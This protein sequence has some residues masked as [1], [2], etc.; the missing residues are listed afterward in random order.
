MLMTG[1]PYF[2]I[3]ENTYALWEYP[4]IERGNSPLL[5]FPEY[6]KSQG[7]YTFSSGKHHN[8]KYWIERGFDEIKA[9]FLGGMS[10]HYGLPVKDYDKEN[11]WSKVY[12]ENKLFSSELFANA[13]IDFLTEYQNDKPF[14]MYLSFTAP[15]DPRTSP[16]DFSDLYADNDISLP[17]NFMAKHPFPIADMRSRDELLAKFPR[18]KVD[19]K[20]QIRDY[21]AM[22]SATDHHIGRVLKQLKTSGFDENTVVI[23]AGDNGLALGQ[24]G[25]L[26]K[27]SVY[28]HS[29]KIPL[30]FSGSGIPKNITKSSL[31][32]LHD[33]FPTLVGLI[34]AKQPESIESKNL[35][36]IINGK[37]QE[38]RDSLFFSYNSWRN[39]NLKSYINTTPSGSHRAIR[40]GNLKLIV[41]NKYGVTT[42]Q[43]FDLEKDPWEVNNLI[44]QAH[45]QQ[46]A[47]ALL[48]LLRKKMQEKGDPASQEY[49][50]F[51]KLPKQ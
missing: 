24:H 44:S 40:K 28:E 50:R 10:R 27:Q 19:V 15:H 34:N 9:G 31:V 13:A 22:I 32:Y 3:E 42:E 1:R 39:E 12:R 36:P 7:Y 46:E 25:L 45:Y 38:V 5:T 51:G 16:Q 41:S 30:I 37:Q 43:L 48:T 2:K 18:D 21:Y 4:E 33:I 47:A 23:F 6:L 26:G 17:E 8:G 49:S 35:M 14:L 20:R 11:G 29:V